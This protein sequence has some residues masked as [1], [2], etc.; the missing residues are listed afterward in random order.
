MVQI[1]CRNVSL[2]YDGVVVSQG[3]NFSVHAGDY[4][5]IVR[6]CSE[7]RERE[8]NIFTSNHNMGNFAH[9]RRFL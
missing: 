9:E 2:G 4:F 5:C 1:E 6:N 3:V 8:K 7:N